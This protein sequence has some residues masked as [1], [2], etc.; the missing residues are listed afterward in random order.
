M[1][2]AIGVVKSLGNGTFFVKDVKGEVHP[3]KMGEMVNEGDHV[4]GA[5]TNGADAKIVIDVLLAGA[6]DMILAGDAA[7]QFASSLLSAIFSHHEAVITVNSYNDGV[8]LSAAAEAQIESA[9]GDQSTTQAGDETAAGDTVSDTERLADTFAARDGAIT[10]VTTDLRATAVNIAGTSASSVEA[11]LV[12]GTEPATPPPPSPPPPPPAEAHAPALDVRLGEAEQ[13]VT[14]VNSNADPKGYNL[15]THN[16]TTGNIELD[17]SA[18]SITVGLKSYKT[19]VDDGHIL[20]KDQEGNVIQTI[21]LDSLFNDTD[22][23]N[24]PVTIFIDTPFYAL[25]VLN[26]VDTQDVN[27]EFKVDNINADMIS[28]QYPLDILEASGENLSDISVIGFAGLP[29]GA[30]L[31]NGSDVYTL[32]S[33]TFTFSSADIN[34][35]ASWTLTVPSELSEDVSIVASLTSTQSDGSSAMSYVGVYGDNVITGSEGPDSLDGRDG[36]DTLTLDTQDVLIDGGIG[37]DT[38]IVAGNTNIDFEAWDS[39]ALKNIEVIDLTNGSHELNNLSLDDVVKMTDGNNDIYIVG[40]VG[41]KVDFL[42][43]NGWEISTTTPTVT[44]MINGNEYTFDVYVNNV[45]PTV[46]VHVEQVITDTILP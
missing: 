38:L 19:D 45:D 6:G 33:D 8:A 31:S 29:E 36:N 21:N 41:D 30:I 14:S 39:S 1:A 26:Y 17:G 35:P 13:V 24:Q 22:P 32:D 28:Y 40:D 4:Y 27:S 2:Q 46:T 20:L 37:T 44:Q 10:D 12:T 34:V 16:S 15:H 42:D 23:H 18:N 9:M 3:L 5:A 11:T 43:S 25:E 7:L